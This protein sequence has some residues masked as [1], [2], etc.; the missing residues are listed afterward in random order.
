METLDVNCMQLLASYLVLESSSVLAL[1]FWMDILSY[2]VILTRNIKLLK[3]STQLPA[4]LAPQPR[5]LSYSLILIVCA[6]LLVLIFVV[7]PLL[8]IFGRYGLEPSGTSCTIDYWHGN[9]R[10]YHNYVIFLVI[11]AYLLPISGM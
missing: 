11:F 3:P 7:P 6:W 8:D 9:Y 4:G 1:S 2:L 5:L 10:N